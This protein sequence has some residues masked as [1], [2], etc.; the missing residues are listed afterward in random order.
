MKR[1]IKR[2]TI[3]LYCHQFISA[4]TCAYVFNK[5]NMRSE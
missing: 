2:I 5:V 4:A 3:W 1:L